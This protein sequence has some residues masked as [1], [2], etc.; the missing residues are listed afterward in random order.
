M[1]AS[2]FKAYFSL[3]SCLLEMS[4]KTTNIRIPKA[5][6]VVVASFNYDSTSIYIYI[7]I[8]RGESNGPGGDMR[9]VTLSQ[10]SCRNAGATVTQ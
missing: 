10:F 7:F 6:A 5:V 9:A 3:V 2:G 4:P 8:F 1:N